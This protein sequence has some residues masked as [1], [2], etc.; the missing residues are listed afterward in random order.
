MIQ[1]TVIQIKNFKAGAAI[2]KNTIVMFDSDDDTVIHATGA[3][4]R[5]IGVALAAAA[6]GAR[7]D[8]ALQGVAEVKLGGTIARG[9]DVTSGAAG[10]GVDLSAAATIKSSIGRAMAG[11]D[12]GDVIPVLINVWS[13]VTA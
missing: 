8:V 12:S 11:G 7:L 9:G 4:D 1:A 3:T 6:S 2:N 10:V 5:P 13:A